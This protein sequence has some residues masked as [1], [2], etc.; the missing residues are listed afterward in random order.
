MPESET[1]FSHRVQERLG[2]VFK[3]ALIVILL[4]A[5]KYVIH[6][7]GWEVIETLSLLTTLM[8][9][10][11]FTL[12]ILLS[13]TLS[14][15]KESER[16]VG[17]LSSHI[18]RLRA[19]L[20]LVARDPG[21]AQE[22]DR[23]VRELVHSL[24]V[25]FRR[26]THWRAREIYVHIEAIDAGVQRAAQAG[27]ASSQVRTVQVWLSN[28]VRIV[29]R[30]ETIIETTFLRSGYY[31]AGT[32]LGAALTALLFTKLAP[33]AQ[34][35]ILFGFAGF[36]LVGLFLLISD[37]DNPFAGHARLDLRPMTKLEAWLDAVPAGR[38]GAATAAT[39]G[40]RAPA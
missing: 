34:G 36:L 5:A 25:N 8:G 37:L 28:V 6:Q 18:R 40:A 2:L 20:R 23:Q 38:E 32:V 10:V 30:L 35:L 14:D 29:D 4:V 9:G 27:A 13:G 3:T 19:D 12:A 16:S 31:L 33:F 1:T 21:A 39:A 26:E 11:A 7:R 24:N 17:E 15:F 22:F